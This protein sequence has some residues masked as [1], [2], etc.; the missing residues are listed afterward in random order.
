MGEAFFVK[1]YRKSFWLAIDKPQ[2]ICYNTIVNEETKED[3]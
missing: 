1:F 3:S 2:K